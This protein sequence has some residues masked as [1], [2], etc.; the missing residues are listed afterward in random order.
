[1][2]IRYEWLDEQKIIVTIIIEA[3]WTWKEYNQHIDELM[4]L[5]REQ[6]H[7][8]ATVVDITKMGSLPRDGNVIHILMN[9]DKRMPENI[10]ASCIVGTSYGVNVFMNMLMKLSSHA[11]RIAFFTQTRDEAYTQ[12]MGQHKQMKSEK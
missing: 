1:M 9:V 2:G 10:F 6:K 12:I 3:P 8:T 11:H 7:P 5:I 4:P